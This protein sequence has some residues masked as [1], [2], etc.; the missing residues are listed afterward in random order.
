MSEYVGS[1]DGATKGSYP[2]PD[3]AHAI[4]ALRLSDH[5]QNP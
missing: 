2:I 5:D 1:S 4:S 3:K